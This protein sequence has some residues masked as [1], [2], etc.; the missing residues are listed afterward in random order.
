MLIKVTAREMTYH[1]LIKFLAAGMDH[2]IPK[3][4][5][6]VFLKKDILI[7]ASMGA[8]FEGKRYPAGSRLKGMGI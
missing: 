3:T 1:Q 2:D 4:D 5:N 7:Y 8:T 6:Q